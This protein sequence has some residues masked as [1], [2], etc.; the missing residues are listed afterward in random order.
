M[1]VKK[2]EAKNIVQDSHLV[3]CVLVV[4]LIAT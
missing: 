3:S 1:L 2:D 4:V